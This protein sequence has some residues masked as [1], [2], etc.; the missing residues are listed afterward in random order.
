MSGQDQNVFW[1]TTVPKAGTECL[2]RFVILFTYS[3][4]IN[5]NVGNFWLFYSDKA[6]DSC[7][8]LDNI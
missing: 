3:C 8:C 2:L 6:H 1:K 5:N 7:V 4:D